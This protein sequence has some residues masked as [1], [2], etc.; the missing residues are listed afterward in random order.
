VLAVA[1]D[2]QTIWVAGERGVAVVSRASG[3]QRVL[4][5]PSAIPAPALDVMLDAD[6]AWIATRQGVVRLRRLP[7]GTVR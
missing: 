6:F 1:A 2:S 4:A 5:V 3:V 7:D